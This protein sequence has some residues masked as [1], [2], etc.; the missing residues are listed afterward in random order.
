MFNEMIET[1]NICRIYSI[2]IIYYLLFIYCII[3][4][5][6]LNFLYL[7]FFRFNHLST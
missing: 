6:F 1:I 7:H 3:L 2:I 5:L 4:T